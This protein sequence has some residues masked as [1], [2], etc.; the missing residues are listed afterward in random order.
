VTTLISIKSSSKL[1]PL[2]SLRERRNRAA[3]PELDKDCG[4]ED[5]ERLAKGVEAQP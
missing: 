1:P 3:M 4:L 2:L 5:I